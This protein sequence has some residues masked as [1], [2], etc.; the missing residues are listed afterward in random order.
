MF[1]LHIYGAGSRLI[2]LG[3]VSSI[4]SMPSDHLREIRISSSSLS[5]GNEH[6]PVHKLVD[7]GNYSHEPWFRMFSHFASFPN[8]VTLQLHGGL[9]VCPEFFRAIID[10]PGTPFSSLVEF[11]LQFRPQTADG[12]WYFQ[13]DEDAIERSRRNSEWNEFWREQDMEARQRVRE[14]RRN[15]P[16]EDSDHNQRIYED[17]PFRTGVVPY[18]T[19]RSRPDPDTFSLFLLNAAAAVERFQSL[20]K[21]IIK[22]GSSL[23]GPTELSDWPVVS[24]VFELWYLRAGMPRSPR[25]DPLDFSLSN[26]YVPGDAAYVSQDRLYW[27]VNNAEVWEDVQAAWTAVAGLDAKIVYMDEDRWMKYSWRNDIPVGYMYGYE[28]EL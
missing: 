8:L 7:E 27:R 19:F 12:R 25:R 5:I 14:L 22:L 9:V 28:G 21:F 10:Y 6:I 15:P 3:F 26:P 23:E 20:K 2:F 18:D 24:R 17:G 1:V 11:E 13:K 4:C 16:S